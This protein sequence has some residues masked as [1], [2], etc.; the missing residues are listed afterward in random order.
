[1]A[2]PGILGGAGTSRRDGQAVTG[3]HRQERLAVYAGNVH[4]QV[5]DE[6]HGLAPGVDC[7]ERGAVE[8]EAGNA[9]GKP[10]PEKVPQPPHPRGLLGEFQ[11]R[12]PRRLGEA[13]DSR[14]IERAAPH[15]P[16]LPAAK[17]KRLHA[18]G[19]APSADKQPADSL[20]S[21]KLVGREAGQVGLDRVHVD[22]H[23]AHGLGTVDVNQGTGVVGNLRDRGHVLHHARLIVRK[24]DGDRE[25][26]GPHRLPEVGEPDPARDAAGVSLGHHRQACDLEALPLEVLDRIERGMVV[27]DRDHE[28]PSGQAGRL[29]AHAAFGRVAGPGGAAQE[30]DVGAFG[31]AACEHDLAGRSP[32]RRGER[33]A[34]SLHGVPRRPPHLVG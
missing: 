10:G 29:R 3:E 25:R 2:R 9:R 31:R 28:V 16:F 13:D 11:A 19:P 17:H 22:G 34:G 18:D 32:D 20:R 15:S 27:G 30:G 7:V 5:V 8:L 23:A 4:V 6:P 26:V 14:H 21:V 33:F 1:M 24:Q 12:Q